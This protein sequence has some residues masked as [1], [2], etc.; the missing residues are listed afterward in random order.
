MV[1]PK[2]CLESSFN[3]LEMYAG[4]VWMLI[5]NVEAHAVR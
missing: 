3:S 2:E 1:V 4:R 5:N